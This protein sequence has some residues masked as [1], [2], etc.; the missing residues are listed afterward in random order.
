MGCH[1]CG[2]DHVQLVNLIDKHPVFSSL[3]IQLGH[4]GPL[5]QSPPSIHKDLQPSTRPHNRRL[6]VP[7]GVQGC[8]EDAPHTHS[9]CCNSAVL[10]EVGQSPMASL[11]ISRHDWRCPE[12][13]MLVN[14]VGHDERQRS[15]RVTR[16]TMR[17]RSVRS[18]GNW[19]ARAW[20]EGAG[21]ETGKC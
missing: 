18:T 13:F 19:A 1:E 2:V 11:F 17:W 20:Q 21:V 10:F 3:L 16:T 4:M 6:S 12:G 14:V 7:V 8:Q 15:E 5:E 9:V